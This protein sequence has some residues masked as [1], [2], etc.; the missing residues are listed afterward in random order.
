MMYDV[1]DITKTYTK[2][3]RTITALQGLTFEVKK[4]DFLVVHGPSGSGKSTLLLALGG[5]LRP[6]TGTVSYENTDIYRQST[7]WRN[8]FR[9]FNIGFVFQRF[10]L[11]PYMTVLDNIRMPLCLRGGGQD[12]IDRAA[13]LTERFGIADR[14]TH[15]PPELMLNGSDQPSGIASSRAR[16]AVGGTS[17]LIETVNAA[18]GLMVDGRT[19]VTSSAKTADDERP[20]SD[21]IRT[22]TSLP[23]QTITYSP[24]CRRTRLTPLTTRPGVGI[25]YH[26]AVS[27]L[28]R[29]PA[30]GHGSDRII[31]T[32][33]RHC[34]LEAVP[35]G[36][37]R[38]PLHLEPDP[39]RQVVE[40][41]PP[42]NLAVDLI[43]PAPITDGT[44]FP[45]Y[46]NLVFQ[47]GRGGYRR[48]PP[49][50]P[51]RL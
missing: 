51:T 12:G 38:R 4:G 10:F 8:R 18:P 6:T 24:P 23:L 36:S 11:I 1:R 13:A 37:Q 29:L 28:L 21:P 43:P 22:P 42:L 35:P 34:T 5:M 17:M 48:L 50:K 47:S 33:E 26:F 46:R 31:H 27:G 49:R 19:R 41:R 2:R 30:A 15:T 16:Y 44:H 9:E 40:E 32:I 39:T 3:D 25:R 20:S 45:S 7:L 14:L